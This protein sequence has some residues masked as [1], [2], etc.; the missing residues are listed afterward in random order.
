MASAGKVRKIREE[1]TTE[2]SLINKIPLKK[3]GQK[4]EEE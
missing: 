2:T 1:K 4:L 3:P